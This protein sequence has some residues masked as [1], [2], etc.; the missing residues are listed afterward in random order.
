MRIIDWMLA[1][2]AGLW[3]ADGCFG[4]QLKGR[5][6]DQAG[7]ALSEST[8]VVRSVHGLAARQT[9][10]EQ[11]DYRFE[12][13]AHGAYSVRISKVGFGA[14]QSYEILI[15]GSATLDSQLAAAS[16]VRSVNETEQPITA[17]GNLLREA[18]KPHSRPN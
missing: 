15:E 6:T 9:T 2:L 1:A 8:V 3:A 13:L 16:V 17:P 4:A 11:G 7:A 5:V 12:D 14:H 18:I 10:D